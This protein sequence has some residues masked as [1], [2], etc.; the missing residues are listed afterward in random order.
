MLRAKALEANEAVS[1]RT[2]TYKGRPFGDVGFVR[3]LI[4]PPGP[5]SPAKAEMGCPPKARASAA[6]R[7]IACRFTDCDPRYA[8]P[9]SRGCPDFSPTF[10]VH[11]FTAKS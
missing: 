3:V 11:L 9:I 7:G 5:R 1:L 8:P 6:G 10:S 2:A 4:G